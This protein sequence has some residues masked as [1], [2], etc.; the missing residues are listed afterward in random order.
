MYVQKLKVNAM[1]NIYQIERFKLV[2]IANTNHKYK[3]YKVKCC[4]AHSPN[5]FALVWPQ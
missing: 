3:V 4:V 1:K 2:E 5:T